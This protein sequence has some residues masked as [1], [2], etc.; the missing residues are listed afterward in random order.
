MKIQL[1]PQTIRTKS[2]VCQRFHY[3]PII[4]SVKNKNNNRM[5]FHTQASVTDLMNAE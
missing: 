5:Y 4:D 2:K 3:G 1:S